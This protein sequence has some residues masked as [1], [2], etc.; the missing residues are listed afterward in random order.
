MKS[1]ILVYPLMAAAAAVFVL[2]GCR[3]DKEIDNDTSP[4]SDSQLAENVFNEIKNMNDAVVAGNFQATMYKSSDTMQTGCA[5]VIL[6]TTSNPRSITIDFGPTNCLCQDG[7]YRR[8]VILTTY[9]GGY[10]DSATVITHTFNNYYV[11]DHKINGTK[12]VTNMGHNANNQLYFNVS[13]NGSIVKPNNGGTITWTSNRVRTWIAGESTLINWLDDEYIITGSGNGT[14][15]S[16]TNFNMTITQ[17][18]HVKLNCPRIVAG[19]L[20]ITPAGKPTRTLNYGSGTCDYNA[21]VT[22]N[23]NTYNIVLF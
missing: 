13:V 14:T 5:T 16:G 1:K 19:V 9:T 8:G 7:K 10:R 23:G 12:T 3:K 11:N 6:D 20:D 17:G 18:L 15:A 22:I 2:A 21:T 4:A